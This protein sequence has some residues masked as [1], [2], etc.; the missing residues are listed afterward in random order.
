MPFLRPSID[1]ASLLMRLPS[2]VYTVYVLPLA[3]FALSI[4]DTI[5]GV[6]ASNVTTFF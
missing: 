1:L 2:T 5:T 3:A 4:A 6:A